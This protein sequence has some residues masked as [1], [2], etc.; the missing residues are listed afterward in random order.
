MRGADGA[1]QALFLRGEAGNGPLSGTRYT[2]PREGRTIQ[3]LRD[4]GL[5]V[6]EI[7]G[8]HEDERPHGTNS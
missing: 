1:L 2:R 5:N 4:T 3:A 6:P 7:L 8:S